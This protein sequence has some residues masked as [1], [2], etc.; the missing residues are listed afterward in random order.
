MGCQSSQA[1]SPGSSSRVCESTHPTHWMIP[2]YELPLSPP[3]SPSQSQAD[4]GWHLHCTST[5]RHRPIASTTKDDAE[6]RHPPPQTPSDSIYYPS[7]QRRRRFPASSTPLQTTV[8]KRL[9]LASQRFTGARELNKAR[10]L[11]QRVFRYC[12]SDSLF[13]CQRDV[14]LLPRL[15]ASLR[16]VLGRA[17]IPD[18]IT[19][20]TPF[21]GTTS[22]TSNQSTSAP[23]CSDELP[24]ACSL[25]HFL[26]YL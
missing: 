4:Q 5:A 2:T 1:A 15:V 23:V 21:N 8:V 6:Q 19:P 22:L 12:A 26:C 17:S 20:V 14:L 18:S 11:R 13:R 25:L 9:G 16:R 3:S 24:S 7:D 10:F